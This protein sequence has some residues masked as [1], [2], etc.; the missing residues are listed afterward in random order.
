MDY[1]DENGKSG[2]KRTAIS[3]PPVF[4]ALLSLLALILSACDIT[5][6]TTENA[7]G[8][9][10]SAVTREPRPESTATTRP[11]VVTADP[12][13]VPPVTPGPSYSYNEVIESGPLVLDPILA[14][15]PAS[16][17]V[18]RNV[19]ETLVYP[20]P[21]EA[22]TFIP[23]L[24]TGWR[25]S[26]EGRTYTFSIRRGVRFSNGDAL[27]ASDVA[28]SLQRLLLASP[29][30]GPQRLLLQPLLG[31]QATAVITDATE[32]ITGTVDLD[33]E[34]AAQM[35]PAADIVARL[36]EGRYVGDRAALA[37][38]VPAGTLQSICREIQ[39]AIRANDAEGTLTI[40][41]AQPWRPFLSI[42]S[43]T[44]TSAVDRQWAVER[45]AWDGGCDTWQR[46]YALESHES[47]LANAI[48]GTGPYVLDY[49][50]PGA[51]HVL[52]ANAEYWRGESSMWDGGPFGAPALSS[53]RVM[54]DAEAGNRWNLLESDIAQS[55][56][57][58][59]EEAVSA[60]QQVG[61]I[62][63]WQTQD[64]RTAEDG[65]APLR[66]I[67]NVPQWRQQALFFNFNIGGDENAFLGSGQFDGDGIPPDFFSDEHVR[68][69]F[70]HCLDERTL[71][72][73]GLG[74]A[75]VSVEGLVPAFIHDVSSEFDVFQFELQR[76]SEELALAW[77]GV[78]PDT[79]FRLQA[80]YLS[81]DPVQEAVV[82][83]LSSNLRAVNSA[84]QIEG[85]GLPASLIELAIQEQRS[86]LAVVQ[87]TP[88]IPDAY[89]WLAPAFSGEI[90]AYQRLPLELR[91]QVQDILTSMRE[92]SDG[93]ALDDAYDDVN[94]LHA[95]HVTFVLLPRPS[96]T[97][98]L[99]LSLET[100]LYNAA[101]PLPY[102]YAYALR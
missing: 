51:E 102:Y 1:Y 41:L 38:N 98:Y 93:S 62:C 94:R 45:G 47:A 80:P 96:T 28:Y 55:A 85:V 23:L 3:R 42:M 76:C 87:W 84:Y 86:P 35:A 59:A 7:E 11:I 82:E 88:Q 75:G 57:L 58:L 90:A 66:Q 6:S 22:G 71:I 8:T 78:L 65:G 26:D 61:L 36:D 48:V 70:A 32:T 25:I 92:G 10:G 27:A 97:I 19:M 49:W 12:E 31:L 68:R 15:D 24:A 18:I 67:Q 9:I 39:S 52:L 5:Q 20:H 69:G 64:C 99:Q 50:A 72:D 73:T 13:Q 16:K 29:A 30:Q 54:Y 17:S 21:H 77:D 44:W 40:T 79:G 37:A 34:Q 74:R 81:T 63:D 89:H 43:Q 14:A 56:T 101:D 95:Q 53:V 91:V 46:W 4:F 2:P 100:W 60:Q 83:T 33:G